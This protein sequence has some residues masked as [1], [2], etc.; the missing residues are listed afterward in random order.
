M[1]VA[2]WNVNGI[3]ARLPCV[4]AWLKLGA[5]ALLCF[6]EI[7]C[8]ETHFPRD[9]FEEY[10]YNLAISGQKGFNGVALLSK[11][12]I[13]EI[14]AILPGTEQEEK[15]A[16]YLQVTVA[17]PL[18]SLCII[19]VYLPNGNPIGSDK[20]ALKLSWMRHLFTHLN[21]L[22]REEQPFVVLGDFNVIPQAEDAANPERWK[23][24]ALFQFEPRALYQS[25]CHIG[26]TDAVRSV[27]PLS[28]IF[29][30]WD[31]KMRA[32]E[33]QD[34]IRI[35]H[36]L[37]SPPLADCLERAGVDAFVRGWEKPSDHSPVWCDLRAYAG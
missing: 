36:I 7:K 20:Y 19:P 12:P 1:R 24:D 2:S 32:W 14:S 27:F 25:M 34:G 9:V 35:D 16:R 11:F 18:G 26:L 6:Q 22:L 23:E 37:L 13:E 31:Y 29:T 33:R 5:P 10:G 28:K 17:T 15:Q 4:T 8:L 30:F 3:R 21:N